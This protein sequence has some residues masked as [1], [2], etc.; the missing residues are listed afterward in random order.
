MFEAVQF[1]PDADGHIFLLH[2]DE[3]M[4]L[5]ARAGL[6]L[7]K[8]AYF[9]NPLTHGHMKLGRLVRRMPVGVV[10]A[11]EDWTRCLPQPLARK[12][13]SGLAALFQVQASL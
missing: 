1:K 6:R 2:S 11:I 8:I 13:H 4:D 10:E 5:S 9:A 3:V 7:V 12:L